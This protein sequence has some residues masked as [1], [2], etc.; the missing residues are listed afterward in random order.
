MNPPERHDLEHLMNTYASPLLR[1]AERLVRDSHTAQDIVQQVFIR[2]AC[3][4][5]HK[6]PATEAVR[7]WLYRVTHNKAVDHIR[8]EQRRKKLHE[9]HAECSAPLSEESRQEDRHA[10]V[11]E[12]IDSLGEKERQVVL[13]RLEEGLSYREISR[14]TGLKEGYVGYLLHQAVRTLSDRLARREET[15]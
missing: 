10:L 12:H 13:L 6:R 11:R 1:Y 4:A 15:I 5:D 14:I 3:L 9:R 2:Y 7:A 8:A